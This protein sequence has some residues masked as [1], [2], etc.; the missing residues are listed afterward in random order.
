[1]DV[2]REDIVEY[3]KSNPN[4]KIN[5]DNLYDDLYVKEKIKRGIRDVE[6]GKVVSFKELKKNLEKRNERN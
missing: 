1:M 2:L 5:L 3:V 4:E 6:D